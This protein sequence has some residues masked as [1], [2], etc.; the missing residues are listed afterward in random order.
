MHV[1]GVEFI[2]PMFLQ[3]MN[4]YVAFHRRI[5]TMEYFFN[6]MHALMRNVSVKK[7][8]LC[9]TSEKIFCPFKPSFW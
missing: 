4:V 5:N 8:T 1:A 6:R 9:T 2:L 3:V 7:M